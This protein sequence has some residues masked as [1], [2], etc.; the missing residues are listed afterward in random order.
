M[1][2]A[3]V[4]YWPIWLF[5]A[6]CECFYA[7]VWVYAAWVCI[8]AEIA[9]L[10]GMHS[11]LGC[12]VGVGLCC[13]LGYASSWQCVLLGYSVDWATLLGLQSAMDTKPLKRRA[14]VRVQ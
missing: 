7:V 9:Y 13:W 12:I 6:F 2:L 8:S 1:L 10:L 5:G 4:I 11:W 3:L 14:C